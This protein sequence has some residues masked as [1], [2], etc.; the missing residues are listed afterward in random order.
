MKIGNQK[1]AI[2]L[3]RIFV[4]L[5][6]GRKNKGFLTDLAEHKNLM[7]TERN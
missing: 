6:G 5:G 7:K 2:G 4:R 1:F 3:T